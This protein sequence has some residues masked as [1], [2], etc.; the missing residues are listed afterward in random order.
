MC[1]TVYSK[2]GDGTVVPVALVRK[3]SEVDADVAVE[4]AL[5]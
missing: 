4:T 5:M 3:D 1:K 2:K